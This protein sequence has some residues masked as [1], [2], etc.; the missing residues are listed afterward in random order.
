MAIGSPSRASLPSLSKR[1]TRTLRACQTER[2]GRPWWLGAAIPRA[3]PPP[4]LLGPLSPG[5]RAWYEA[6]L[7]RR[8]SPQL[9]GS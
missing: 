4:P 9:S 6:P 2:S 1:N 7:A 3:P 8:A 5:A